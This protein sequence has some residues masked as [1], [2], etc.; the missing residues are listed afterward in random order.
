MIQ[1]PKAKCCTHQAEIKI[2]SE[3][4]EI[5]YCNMWA[6]KEGKLLMRAPNS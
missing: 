3:K 6:N 4:W 2:N 5:E 1:T